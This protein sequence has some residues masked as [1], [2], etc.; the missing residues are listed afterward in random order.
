M[1]LDASNEEEKA[2]GCGWSIDAK[3]LYHA[4]AEG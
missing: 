4:A 2:F 1:R 3:H